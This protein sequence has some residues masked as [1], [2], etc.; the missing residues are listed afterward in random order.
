MENEPQHEEIE[1][2]GD[3][4]IASG[5]APVPRWLKFNYLFWILWGV[6]WF[7]LFWNGSWGWL[8]RGYWQQ[9]QRA[10]GTVYPFQNQSD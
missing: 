7:F 1:L 6:V 2:Y 8:D 10:A 4:S 5:D 9:L 3:Q